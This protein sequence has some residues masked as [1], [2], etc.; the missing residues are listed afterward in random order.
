MGLPPI[1]FNLAAIL[2]LPGALTI[3]KLFSVASAGLEIRYFIN[4]GGGGINWTGPW[5]LGP[6]PKRGPRA[7]PGLGP[8][9]SG[10]G[11]GAGSRAQVPGPGPGS[12][13]RALVP[14]PGHGPWSRAVGRDRK[15]SKIVLRRKKSVLG[16]P[17][18]ADR[19][20]SASHYDRT[21]CRLT[22]HLKEK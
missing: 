7:R 2:L 22:Q 9:V 10:P 3:C 17:V 12:R 18:C 15:K 4:W 11:P 21:D 6:G 20:V 8:L 13:A 1:V 16:W 14:D 19:S 5:A